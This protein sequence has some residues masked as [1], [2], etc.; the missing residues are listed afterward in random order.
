MRS[1]RFFSICWGGRRLIRSRAQSSCWSFWNTKPERGLVTHTV[2][3]N[4]SIQCFTTKKLSY[5]PFTKFA[6]SK[7]HSLCQ[8]HLFFLINTD[9]CNT[10]TSK[11][12]VCRTHIYFIFIFLIII[13]C[14]MCCCPNYLTRLFQF[15]IWIWTE[16]RLA[17]S[18]KEQGN[19]FNNMFLK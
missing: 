11:W 13:V 3:L 9:T 7:Y 17:Q 19:A 10:W 8:M 5:Q 15:M 4:T 2:R 12:E 1:L 14:E 18:Q 6:T 16:C